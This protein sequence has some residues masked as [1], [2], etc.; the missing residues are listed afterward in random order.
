LWLQAR[1]DALYCLLSLL[2][3]NDN[4]TKNLVIVGVVVS[5]CCL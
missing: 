1:G 4:N 5:S 3:G 2:I